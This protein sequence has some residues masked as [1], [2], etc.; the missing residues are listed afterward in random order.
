MVDLSGLAQALT[1]GL[2]EASVIALGAVGLTLSYGVTRFI[3]FAYGEFLAW[4]A[5]T[6]VLIGAVAPTLPL[7]LAVA[8][9]VVAVGFMGVAV[10]GAFFEPIAD[11]GGLPLLITSIGV[12]FVLRYLLVAIASTDA[13]SLPVPLQRPVEWMGVGLT[14]VQAVVIGVAALAMLAIHGVL[15]YTTL[16]T[17]MRATSG[18][19]E[20]ATV[21]G[22]DTEAVIRRTWVISAGAAALAGV[23][24]TV[25]YAPVRPTFGFGYLIIIFAATLLGGIGRPY[26]AMLGAV[27]IGVTI[28]LGSAYLSPAYDQAYA[29]IVLVLVL[30]V[31]PEGIRRGTF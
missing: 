22:I 11:R 21:A 4:G 27:L 24:Y 9:A 30:L 6:V 19:R 8:V 13:R 10:S 20:L 23:L 2:I 1:F 29:F 28:S 15:Q 26:G 5:F 7:P 31:R 18:N 3:N 17:V 25:L 14:P 12:A 16:G